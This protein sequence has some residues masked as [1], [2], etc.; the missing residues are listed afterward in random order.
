MGKVAQVARA[1]PAHSKCARFSGILDRSPD[2][3]VEKTL[4]KFF[5]DGGAVVSPIGC[6]E[7]GIDGLEVVPGETF[8]RLRCRT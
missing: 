8:P 2:A 6:P 5:H 1:D 3:K 7:R 4:H